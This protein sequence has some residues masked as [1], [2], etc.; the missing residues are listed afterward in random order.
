LIIGS[1][2]CYEDPLPAALA[3]TIGA[4]LSRDGLAW[5]VLPARDWPGE[6]GERVIERFVKALEKRNLRVETERAPDLEDEEYEG[7]TFVKH[8]EG[9]VSVFVT[10]RSRDQKSLQKS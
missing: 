1:D 8:E 7:G 9:T 5:L 6:T 2:V 4:R 3:A 10:R